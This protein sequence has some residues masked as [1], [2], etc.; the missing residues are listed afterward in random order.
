VW[1]DRLSSTSTTRTAS[2]NCSSTNRRAKW[3]K[4]TPVS[5]SVTSMCRHP[6]SGSNARNRSATP[7]RWYSWCRLAGEPGRTGS[8]C[9]TSP[10]NCLPPSP[11]RTTG[12]ESPAGRWY[13][14]GTSSVAAT[15]AA[16]A[17]GGI[18]HCCLSH[19]FRSFF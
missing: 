5:R 15:N 8:G 14:A 6:V 3:A 17:F 13:T 2:A 7:F 19:G 10:I 11:T 18:T 4:S 12:R 9:R 16:A 1:V